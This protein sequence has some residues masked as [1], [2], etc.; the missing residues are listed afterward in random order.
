MRRYV[1]LVA[2]SLCALGACGGGG[3][4][5]GA[6]TPTPPPTPTTPKSA[7]ASFYAADFALKSGMS[8]DAIASVA[9]P[10]KGVAMS[11]AAYKTCLVRATDHTKDGTSTFAR[12][13]YSRRQAFNADGSRFLAYAYDGFWHLYDANTYTRIRALSGP[14]ADAE[15][16]WHATNPDLLYY[17][18]TNG[19]GMK[20][21]EL[22]VTTGATRVV[23][24]FSARLK[25]RWSGANAAWTKSEGSPSANGR[26]W[27]FM[28]DNA[29]WASLGVFTW[30]RDTD[31]ILGYYNTNGERPDHVSMSPSGNYCVVS[32]DTARGT[33]AFSRDFTQQTKLLPKSEHSDLALDANGDDVYVSVDYAS[34]NGSVFMLNLRTGVRTDLFA[35]YA[36]GTATAL[37]VS[38]KAFNK[39]GWA[40]VS[41]YADYGG[42]RQWLHKKVFA[43][44]LTA[45]P[46]IYNIAHTH[47]VA[48]GY[49]TEPHASVSRDFTKIL[50]NSNWDVNSANDIDAYMI[51]LP[52]GVLK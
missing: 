30:D 1:W 22:N 24:D 43:V 10:T 29:S 20:L 44:K 32:G 19:V 49:W 12:N 15:P 2:G 5:G 36:A 18:P 25:A 14:A 28:V 11:E 46:T 17:I 39:P 48:N 35:T 40:L 26:Y 34:N 37:H 45:N 9:K 27:C 50:F 47:A 31:T 3:A 8:N 21:N 16:Q 42:A 51:E 7:C 52:A 38:G 6:D 33:V 41:T 13:D 23:G 4:D